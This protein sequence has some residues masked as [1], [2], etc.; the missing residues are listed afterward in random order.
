MSVSK[1]CGRAACQ[2]RLERPTRA[3]LAQV[4]F[5]S[6]RCATLA[7]LEGGW[8]PRPIPRALKVVGGRRGGLRRGAQCQ[9][10]AIQQRVAAVRRLLPASVLEALG[11][12]DERRLLV[13][14]GRIWA[15]GRKVGYRAGLRARRREDRDAARQRTCA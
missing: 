14:V 6:P 2:R 1:R 12:R 4:T 8:R 9:R 15:A 13:L 5:C 3:Q 7:R 11:D 10:T